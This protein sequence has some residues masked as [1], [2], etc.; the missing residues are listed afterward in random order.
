MMDTVPLWVYHVRSSFLVFA[1]QEV[2]DTAQCFWDSL[3]TICSPRKNVLFYCRRNR[4]ESMGTN[5]LDHEMFLKTQDA[6]VTEA[7]RITVIW[8]K[9]SLIWSLGC[10]EELATIVSQHWSWIDD[11]KTVNPKWS[12]LSTEHHHL[13]NNEPQ[14]RNYYYS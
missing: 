1:G 6:S 7:Y 3:K 14:Q 4:S 9:G 12:P 11:G 2:N 5:I 10:S 13:H 8:S